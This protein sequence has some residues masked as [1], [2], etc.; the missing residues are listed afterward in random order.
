M[1]GEAGLPVWSPYPRPV[2]RSDLSR[3][4]E[5]DAE[6]GLIE[7][8]STRSS[9]HRN[10]SDVT[11]EPESIEHRNGSD[12]YNDSA[13]GRGTPSA[14]RAGTGTPSSFP[15]AVEKL[16]GARELLQRFGDLLRNEWELSSP[17]SDD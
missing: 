4:A 16:R 12:A 1:G 14:S 11:A 10:G 2:S 5:L 13:D 9:E 3:Y 7:L 6:S 15:S 17:M 8:S